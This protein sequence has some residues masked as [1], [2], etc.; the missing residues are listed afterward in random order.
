MSLFAVPMDART[1]HFH[2]T[3]GY[4]ANGCRK[5]QM[6]SRMMMVMR[7]MMMMLMMMMVMMTRHC[8]G[9][10]AWRDSLGIWREFPLRGGRGGSLSPGRSGIR[11]PARPFASQGKTQGSPLGGYLSWYSRIMPATSKK[12]KHQMTSVPDSVNYLK[13]EETKRLEEL[14]E[15]TVHGSM[16]PRLENSPTPVS[17]YVTLI[18]EP[19]ARAHQKWTRRRQHLQQLIGGSVSEINHCS[20]CCNFLHDLCQSVLNIFEHQLMWFASQICLWSLC[21][22]LGSTWG[23]PQVP[24]LLSQSKSA[25]GKRSGSYGS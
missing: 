13:T 3:I 6:S 17:H 18:F 25:S 15:P 14:E 12:S 7:R 4:G 1:C 16:E 22:V 20:I 24:G 11:G 19:L 10:A 21:Q 5:I 8:E 23:V 9:A 2:R